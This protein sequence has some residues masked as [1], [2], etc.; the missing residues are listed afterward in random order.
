VLRVFGAFVLV[1][2]LAGAQPDQGG[3]LLL[4]ASPPAPRAP[5]ALD[6]WLPTGSP[7][8]TAVVRPA[9]GQEPAA[10][11]LSY[12]LCVHRVGV[13]G[14][15]AHAVLQALEKAYEQLVLAMGLPSFLPDFGRGGTDGLDVYVRAG[16][17]LELSVSYDCPELDFADRAAAFCVLDLPANAGLDRVATQCVGE[18]IALRLDASESPHTRRGFATHLWFAAG[19]PSAA[20]SQSRASSERRGRSRL[21]GVFG[22][23]PQSQ[24]GRSPV[25]G[26]ASSLRGQDGAASAT[27]GQRTGH[28]RRA[29]RQPA[30]GATTD[31]RAHG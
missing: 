17:R 4:G 25:L 3:S 16:N 8:F 23:N 9:Q 27:V 1:S 28:L 2:V 20:D 7:V 31:G 21:H 12:P 14:Q 18:A 11:S 15:T 22:R 6:P 29:A 5:V 10:C 13:P 24:R 30:R 26:F 19:Q